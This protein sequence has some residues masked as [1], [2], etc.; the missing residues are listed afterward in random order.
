[1]SARLLLVFTLTTMATLTTYGAPQALWE[2]LDQ[3]ARRRKAQPIAVFEYPVE[4]N[5]EVR[6]WIKYFQGSGRL[7][8]SRWLSRSSR[9]LPSINK[10]FKEEGLPTDLAYIAM[11]ESGL[12]S[13]AVSHAK[14]VG[15]WQ[16]IASTGERF[17]LETNWW[18]DE[19][20][21]FQK[22]TRAAAKYLKHLY[23]MFD[24]WNLAA[25]SYNAGENRIARAMAKYQTRDFWE[26]AR[27]GVL[28]RETNNYVPKLIA[29]MLI[30]KTPSLYGFK[31]IQK[32]KPLEFEY[33]YVPGG[34]R[35]ETLASQ[36]GLSKSSLKELNPELIRGYIPVQAGGREIRIPEGTAQRVSKALRA[37]VIGKN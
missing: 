31:N 18:L 24:C 10:I 37:Q 20:R 35:L 3:Q 13:H 23:S 8:F 22:S 25:A 9:Y 12:T 27:L 15:P 1:M 36:A 16:F 2:S 30:A 33:I 28:A 34:T 6:H 11:I 21:D 29:T 14:A 4:Y 5:K 32:Q 19:R 26:I 7:A 17:G